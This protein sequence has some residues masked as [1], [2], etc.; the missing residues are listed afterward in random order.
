[1][2]LQ[3]LLVTVCLG[4]CL[5]VA[6]AP[7]ARAQGSTLKPTTITSPD[8]TDDQKAEIKGFVDANKEGL[9]GDPLEIK[10][11]RNTL[12]QPFKNQQVSVAFRLEYTRDLLPVLRPLLAAENEVKAVNA[13]RVAGE[14]ATAGSVELLTD[15]LNDKRE[16]VRY[17][18]ASGFE[19]TFKAM[20]G[21]VP[22]L[23]GAPALRMVDTVKAALVREKNPRVMEGLVLAFQEASRI[24]EKQVEGMRDA[25]VKALS[26]AVVAKVADRKISPDA[27]ASLRRAILTVRLA[28]TIQDISAPA[29]QRSTLLAGAEMAGDL[30]ALA[31]ER[32]KTAAAPDADLA[33]MVNESEKA[34]FFIQPQLAASPAPKEFKVWQQVQQGNGAEY[35]KQVLQIIGPNGI[36]TT[37]PFNFKDDRFIKNP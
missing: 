3:R 1:M 30:L 17:A 36:L 15:A 29:L 24:S 4:L 28:V 8:L 7:H 34:I 26:E 5:F 22:V 6:G 19:N 32:M 21:T 33:L 25:G 10:K 2:N 35:R 23:G 37:A 13:V 14:L 16:G 11:S 12:L 9:M 27:D 20:Q 18:A 31:A